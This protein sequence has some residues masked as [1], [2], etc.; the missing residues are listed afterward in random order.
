MTFYGKHE[1][2]YLFN[3][4][5]D[6]ELP[7]YNEDLINQI[8]LSNS[9][10]VVYFAFTSLSSVGL[11]DLHPKSDI[12]RLLTAFILLFGVAIFSY[13]MGNLLEIFKNYAA[14]MGIVDRKGELDHWIISLQRF[15]NR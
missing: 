8:A 11:G 14:K 13:I 1:D 5:V 4:D 10:K 6:P 12:E 7:S 3:Y 15:T 9:L 2:S